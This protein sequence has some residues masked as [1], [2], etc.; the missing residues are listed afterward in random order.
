MKIVYNIQAI[1]MDSIV[2]DKNAVNILL[3]TLEKLDDEIESAIDTLEIMSDPE[4]LNNIEEGLRDIK[5]G[6]FITFE[7][8]LSKHGC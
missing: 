5:E 3:G 8:F 2:E 1:H 4:T 6:R 7:D